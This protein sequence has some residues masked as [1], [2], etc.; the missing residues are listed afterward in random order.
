[1]A[2]EKYVAA[3]VNCSNIVWF[4]QLLERMKVEIKEP[5]VM[6]CEN[7]SANKISK[8]PVMHSKTM[9]ISIKYHFVREMVQDKEIRLEYVHI[10]EQ[11]ADIFTK[12]LPKDAFMYLRGKLGVIPLSEAY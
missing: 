4:K 3:V 11:I 8:N 9:H 2:K 5:V 1:M 10:K 12:P 7:A 6:F